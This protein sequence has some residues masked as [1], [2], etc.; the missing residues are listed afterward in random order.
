MHRLPEPLEV[1]AGTFTNSAQSSHEDDEG[2]E[3]LSDIEPDEVEG[4]SHRVNQNP[5]TDFFDNLKDTNLLSGNS[6]KVFLIL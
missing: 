6:R 4:F 2:I 3:N 5:V 1:A